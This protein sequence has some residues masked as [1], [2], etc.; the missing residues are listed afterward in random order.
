MGM[1]ETILAAM[2]GAAATM[3]TAAFQLFLAFRARTKAE[4]KPKK[5]AVRSLLSVF[6]II[7]ASAVGGFAYSELRA[8]RSRE[9]IR[10]LRAELT[11]QFQALAASSTARF[12]QLRGA[13]G[14]SPGLLTLAT[15]RSPLAGIAESI[16][17]VPA[18]Q[19][20]PPAFGNQPVACAERDADRLALCAIVPAQ[21]SVQ[22]VQ[23]FARVTDGVPAWDQ[24][25]VAFDQDAGG[26]RFTGAPFELAEGPEAKAVC[27]NAEHWNS[28]RAH[29]L[30]LVVIFA[31]D[32][33]STAARAVAAP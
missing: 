16:A 31:P 10:G 2:I 22:D 3:L 27:A 6:A 18:C 17:Q 14:E 30:R 19:S 9:D 26:V 24:S 4:S 5:G 15:A 13:S 29:T 28:E 12:E 1:S 21:A 25:K 11:E 20:Q 8:E 7:L 23:L 32:L 33:N